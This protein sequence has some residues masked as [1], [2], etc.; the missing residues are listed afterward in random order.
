LAKGR[1]E[2]AAAR[3]GQQRL[4]SAMGARGSKPL[5]RNPE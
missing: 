2:K 4:M 5:H 1:E 3:A